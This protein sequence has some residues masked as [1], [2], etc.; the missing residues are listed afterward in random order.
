MVLGHHQE[1]PQQPQAAHAEHRDEHGHQRLAR[2][3]DGAGQQ[4]HQNIGDVTGSQKQHH[5]HADLQHVGVGA[6]DRQDGPGQ[7]HQKGAHGDGDTGAHSYRNAYAFFQTVV[8]A[9]AVVLPGKGGEGLGQGGDGH[10]EQDV[11]LAVGRPGGHRVGIKG[12]DA[13]LNDDVGGGVHHRLEGGGHAHPQDGGHGLTVELEGGGK[14]LEG[15]AVGAHEGDDHQHRRQHLGGHGGNGHPQHFQGND[16]HQQK[17]QDDVA[18]GGG[19]EEVQGPL[20]IPHRPEHAGAHVI[21]HVGNHA[22]KVD[23]L[24]ENGPGQGVGGGVHGPER[25]GGEHKAYHHKDRA[26][27]DRQQHGGVDAFVDVLPHAGAVTL[28]NGHHGSGG[29][30]G[31][32]AHRQVDDHAGGAHGGQGHLAH[33]PAHHHRVHGIVQLLEEGAEPQGKE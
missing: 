3:P 33:E 10:P 15:G 29:Q 5:L 28:G 2:P 8:L 22:Q 11:H 30:A 32:D 31:K 21:D 17:V 19:N 1:K 20:G 25:P 26:D 9:R 23:P 12:V 27:D 16:H 7:Q 13:G 14:E 4:L 6:E 24:V 18:Q